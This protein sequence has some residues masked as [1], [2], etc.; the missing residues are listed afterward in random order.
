MQ[1]IHGRSAPPRALTTPEQQRRRTRAETTHDAEPLLRRAGAPSSNL[2]HNGDDS[3]GRQPLPHGGQLAREPTRRRFASKPISDASKGANPDALNLSAVV[4]PSGIERWKQQLAVRAIERHYLL[5]S[6][7]NSPQH[8]Y[9]DGASPPDWGDVC[10]V[11]RTIRGSRHEGGLTSSTARYLRVR[12]QVA[13]SRLARLIA[14]FWRVRRPSAVISVIG[15]AHP[16]EGGLQLSPRLSHLF[17]RGLAAAVRATNALV[18]SGGTGTGIMELVGDA[19]GEEGASAPNLLGFYSWGRI[20]NSHRL[21]NN[22]GEFEPRTL[23]VEAAGGGGSGPAARSVELEAHHSHLVLVDSAGESGECGDEAR[24]RDAVHEAY[25][26]RYDVPSV[27]V[28]VQGGVGA[29]MSVED[30]LLHRRCAVLALADSGGAAGALARCL[31]AYQAHNRKLSGVLAAHEHGAWISEEARLRRI[32]D[33]NA[34]LGASGG[35]LVAYRMPPSLGASVTT[36]AEAAAPL[37]LHLLRAI[38][39]RHE[40]GAAEAAIARASRSRLLDSARG[41]AAA[42]GGRAGARRWQVDTALRCAVEW[43]RVDLVREIIGKLHARE[44]AAA[45]AVTTGAS[46]RNG[47]GGGSLDGEG[48]ADGASEARAAEQGGDGALREGS[49]ALEVQ[50]ALQLALE[51]QRVAIVEV[52]LTHGASLPHVNLVALYASSD[53]LASPALAPLRAL[54]ANL[55]ALDA[56]E[57]Q[58]LYERHVVPFL[59]RLVPTYEQAFAARM[60][61]LRSSDVF[62]WAVAV[63]A[64]PLASMLWRRTTDPVRFGLLAAL[65]CRNQGLSPDGLDAPAGDDA[66]TLG[67]KAAE[68]EAHAAGVLDQT[69]SRDAAAGGGGASSVGLRCLGRADPLWGASLLELAFTAEMKAFLSHGQCRT[70]VARMTNQTELLALP[71]ATGWLAI[72]RQAAL[73]PLGRRALLDACVDLRRAGWPKAKRRL[74]LAEQRKR[75]PEPLAGVPR[76]LEFLRIP[77]VKQL[78]RNALLL[79]H[80]LLFI[81]VLLRRAD[82]R[83]TLLAEAVLLWWTL[84]LLVDRWHADRVSPHAISPSSRAARRVDLATHLLLAIALVLSW[85]A[86]LAGEATRDFHADASEAAASSVVVPS[87]DFAHRL[88]HPPPPSPPPFRW[89]DPLNSGGRRLDD[90]ALGEATVTARGGIGGVAADGGGSGGAAHA[91]AASVAEQSSLV[92]LGLCAIPLCVR[93]LRLLTEH[94]VLGVLTITLG[95]MLYDVALFLALFA[96]AALG[97]GLALVALLSVR[98]PW[99]PILDGTWQGTLGNLHH[100]AAGGV[101]TSASAL[102]VPFWAALGETADSAGIEDASPLLGKGLLWLYLVVA[103]LVLVN[104]TIAMMANTFARHAADAEQEFDYH[105]AAAAIESRELFIVPPPFSLPVLLCSPARWRRLPRRSDEDGGGGGESELQRREDMQEVLRALQRY[106]TKGRSHSS[107]ALPSRMASVEDAVGQL[108]DRQAEAAEAIARVERLLGGGAAPARRAP[109]PP[110]TAAVRSPCPSGG[111]SGGGSAGG[112][113]GGGGQSRN[114]MQLPNIGS[115]GEGGARAASPRRHHPKP[116]GGGA[117]GAEAAAPSAAEMGEHA[118]AGGGGCTLPAAEES[119]SLEHR[120]AVASSASAP[121]PVVPASPTAPGGPAGGRGRGA[122]MPSGRSSPRGRPPPSPRRGDCA[123]F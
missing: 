100:E 121:P 120:P 92:L 76:R 106:L 57:Q 58:A 68:F 86:A 88:V 62:L 56:K 105:A 78:T 90:V 30:A 61:A 50:R 72:L 107:R 80:V 38:V 109:P 26:R 111:G 122:A 55:R 15:G 23:P 45:G 98:A 3:R 43:D 112:G 16:P 79:V 42:A 19:V 59:A 113:G 73:L 20:A 74:P 40:L 99:Q 51:H 94:R 1:A 115:L 95:K 18:V 36:S 28:V 5:Q 7:H 27:L 77:R 53:A 66:E 41:A 12:Q 33:A 25:C 32:C 60:R 9:D 87:V 37:E 83:P 65:L 44:E 10:F 4:A 93:L 39:R 49:A 34:A 108:A 117:C 104:L 114:G 31:E 110:S 118:S 84:N 89:T 48:A 17:A 101:W 69:S 29:L 22:A 123:S 2:E 96:T 91:P 70:L 14:K 8:L 81:L 85:R 82:A 11:G 21:A 102:S 6:K 46:S 75:S 119:Q 97:F 13:P 63:G 47:G 67:L 64:W 52:L 24:L 35:L 71:R 116:N 54:P 103:Q